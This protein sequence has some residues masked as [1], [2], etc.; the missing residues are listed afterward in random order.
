MEN[1]KKLLDAVKQRKGIESDYALAKFLELPRPR[2]HDYY[3]GK[4]APDDFACLQIAQALGKPLA[5]VVAAVRMDAEKDEKRRSAWERY[6]K[7]IGG[8]AA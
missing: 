4:A 6:Y 3:K 8:I 7:G 5:E 2:I 1:V